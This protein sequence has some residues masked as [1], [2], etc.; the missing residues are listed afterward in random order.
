MAIEADG[1][2]QLPNPWCVLNFRC[3]KGSSDTN[4]GGGYLEHNGLYARYNYIYI[5][6]YI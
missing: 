2:A 6:I 1:F 5:Y 3:T 4:H